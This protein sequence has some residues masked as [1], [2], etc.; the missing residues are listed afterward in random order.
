MQ[1]FSLKKKK[2]CYHRTSIGCEQCK[3]NRVCNENG[4]THRHEYELIKLLCKGIFD[5]LRQTL[6]AGTTWGGGGRQGE[7]R[8]D[9]TFLICITIF[10]TIIFSHKWEISDMK[11]LFQAWYIQWIAT[12]KCR[13]PP[14]LYGFVMPRFDLQASPQL[15]VTDALLK[16]CCQH[17]VL[18]SQYL[19]QSWSPLPKSCVRTDQN[20]HCNLLPF[21][22]FLY[23]KM[24]SWN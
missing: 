13:P 23:K 12:R 4:P 22:F 2:H 3:C 18:P 7:A 10:P 21:K 1:G 6:G 24:L 17:S 9:P 20:N 8:L 16:Q 19:F 15:T 11:Y 14:H 5:H